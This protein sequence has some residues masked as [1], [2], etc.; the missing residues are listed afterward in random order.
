MWPRFII[1]SSGNGPNYIDQ[2]YL[3]VHCILKLPFLILKPNSMSCQDFGLAD[4]K[5]FARAALITKK[6]IWILNF[7]KPSL[8][9]AFWIS[10]TGL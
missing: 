10:Y 8:F 9:I 3:V 4:G 2:K 7:V 1:E 6:L 5:I